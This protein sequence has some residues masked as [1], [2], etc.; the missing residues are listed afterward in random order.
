MESNFALSND[1]YK[2]KGILEL[3]SSSSK[4]PFLNY[5]PLVDNLQILDPFNL[6]GLN[7]LKPKGFNNIVDTGIVA[8]LKSLNE[9]KLELV[10]LIL[11][12]IV[13]MLEDNG[14]N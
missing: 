3:K 2:L 9:K 4:A 6:N 8:K 10:L 1:I 7:L 14:F 13:L 11:G 12:Y 5:D